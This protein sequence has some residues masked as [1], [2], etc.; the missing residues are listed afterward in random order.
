LVA[1]PK[2]KSGIENTKLRF[3]FGI[4]PDGQRIARH[5]QLSPYIFYIS[6]GAPKPVWKSFEDERKIFTF[7]VN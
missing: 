4:E 2:R 6:I 1:E 3:K 5:H 7:G